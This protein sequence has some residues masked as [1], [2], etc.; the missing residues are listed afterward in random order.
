MNSWNLFHETQI[1]SLAAINCEINDHDVE[2]IGHV[3]D[4]STVG[5]E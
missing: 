4:A 5:R 3:L 1:I 2:F